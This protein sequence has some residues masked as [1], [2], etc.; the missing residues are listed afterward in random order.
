MQGR[1]GARASRAVCA[2]TPGPWQPVALSRQEDVCDWI[3]RPLEVLLGREGAEPR[4]Q[5]PRP[6]EPGLGARRGVGGAAEGAEAGWSSS[7]GR[8]ERPE[9]RTLQPFMGA[10]LGAR[11]DSVCVCVCP[12]GCVPA[13]LYRLWEPTVELSGLLLRLTV[14]SVPEVRDTHRL[15]PAEAVCVVC[16]RTSSPRSSDTTLAAQSQPRR[17]Y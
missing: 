15:R 2:L 11:R 3:D 7:D 9:S 4:G 17:V 6:R 14:I 8:G 10:G 13:G 12:Q 1:G 16:H 5:L